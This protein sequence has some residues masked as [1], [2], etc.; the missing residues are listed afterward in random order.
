MTPLLIHR[1]LPVTART[2]GRCDRPEA[3]TAPP[4]FILLFFSSSVKSPEGKRPLSKEG[5]TAAQNRPESAWRGGASPHPQSGHTGAHTAK[6]RAQGGLSVYGYHSGPIRLTQGRMERP[7]SPAAGASLC[8]T[9]VFSAAGIP[10]FLSAFRPLSVKW[11]RASARKPRWLPLAASQT[12]R[13][14]HLG[15][16]R[17]KFILSIRLFYLTKDNTNFKNV[18]KIDNKY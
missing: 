5:E 11:V 7:P 3:P 18:L 16:E 10:S 13:L 14:P 4:A 12:L 15:S 2:A 8:Y 1:K 6:H 9:I 17:Y